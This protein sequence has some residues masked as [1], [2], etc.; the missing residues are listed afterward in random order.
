MEFSSQ[1]QAASVSRLPL[2]PASCISICKGGK[3]ITKAH[4]VADTV[5]ALS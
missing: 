4:D 1:S 3:K 5:Q 2:A